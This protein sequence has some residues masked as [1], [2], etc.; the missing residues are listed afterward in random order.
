MANERNRPGQGPE[1]SEMQQGIERETQAARQSAQNIGESAKREAREMASDLQDQAQ[2]I[3]SG[4]KEAAKSSMM[5]ISS[6][7]RRAADDLDSH[8]QSQVAGMARS[9][10]DGIEDFSQSLSRRNFQDML[11]DVQRFARDHPAAFFGG[12]LI[13]GLA[14]ARFA[15]SSS[16]HTGSWSAGATQHG[17]RAGRRGQLAEFARAERER[18]PEAG[19]TR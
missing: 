6:A 1:K 10:A 8:E 13:A 14:I 2:N 5:D 9:L 11:S 18:G 7:I 16:D 19:M 17:G 4:Q 3:L 15:K 12:A